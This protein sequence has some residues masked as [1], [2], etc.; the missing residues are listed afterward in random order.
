MDEIIISEYNTQWPGAFLQEK[1]ILEK[2]LSTENVLTIEHFG[3]TAIPGL[4]AKPII[5]IIIAVPS[6]AAV[7]RQFVSKLSKIDYVFWADNPETDKLFFVKGM[8][9]YGKVRTHHVHVVEKPSDLQQRLKFRDYLIMDDAERDA[10]ACL[11]R[12]LAVRHA[13]DREAYTA[14]KSAFVTRILK[15]ADKH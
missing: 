3:S 5:D 13:N 6:V 4:P 9:P 11:K 12:E 10:Y 15:L 1:E 8:P 14:A 7:R 2:K